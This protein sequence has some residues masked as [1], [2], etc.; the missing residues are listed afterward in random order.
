MRVN[1]E[2]VVEED[3]KEEEQ[4]ILKD[5][6]LINLANTNKNMRAYDLTDI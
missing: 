3:E 4:H 5:R 6:V 1:R 2:P